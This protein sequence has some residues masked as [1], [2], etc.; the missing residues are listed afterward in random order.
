MKVWVDTRSWV[1]IV[2]CDMSN[3]LRCVATR[4]EEITWVE[5]E[6]SLFRHVKG[7]PFELRTA[8]AETSDSSERKDGSA[9]VGV[10]TLGRPA[11]TRGPQQDT[12]KGASR[13]CFLHQAAKS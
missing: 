11:V 2:D 12:T 7:C 3:Q 9:A 13:S 5:P 10:V 1:A 8:V 6:V 4:N